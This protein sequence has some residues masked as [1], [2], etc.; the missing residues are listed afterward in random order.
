M[1]AEICDSIDCFSLMGWRYRKRIKIAPGIHLNFSKRGASAT[2]GPRGASVNIGPNGTYVNTGIPNTG[3]YN[4]QKISSKAND[5]SNHNAFSTVHST[6][7]GRNLRSGKNRGE[8]N[9]DVLIPLIGLFVII[10]IVLVYVFDNHGIMTNGTCIFVAAAISAFVVLMIYFLIVAIK[11]SNENEN[12]G[13][14]VEISQNLDSVLDDV[15]DGDEVEED[16]EEG[17]VEEEIEEPWPPQGVEIEPYDPKSDLEQYHYPTI[18]LLRYYEQLPYADAKQEERN[19]ER[20]IS[21]LRSFGVE[22]SAVRCTI[23]PSVTLYEIMLAPGIRASRLNGLE[24]D[25]AL[26]MCSHNV[27]IHP[28]S[29]RGIISI[30][31]PNISPHL[32]PI[33]C[34]IQRRCFQETTMELP[35][36][37]G[38]T[39]HNDVFMFDLAKAP[40]LLIAGSAGQG[41][42]M[43][44]HVIITSLLYKCH[45]SE[46]KFVLMDPVGSEL[47]QYEQLTG[48]FLASVPSV[49]SIVTNTNDALKTLESLRIE[50]HNRYKLFSMAGA[51][52][53]REYDELFRN[54]Q[55]NPSRGH[56]YMPRIVVVIDSYI[57]L[58]TGHEQEMTQALEQLIEGA[59]AVG[60]HIIVS[61]S[62]PSSDILSSAI[63]ANMPTRISFA[64]PE[65]IDSHI[66]LGCNGAE[67][68]IR[69]GDMIFKNKLMFERIQCAY[70]DSYETQRIVSSVSSQQGYNYAF[71]LPS[72]YNDEWRTNDAD[73][74]HLDPLFEDVALYIVQTKKASTSQI[75]DA[76]SIGYNRTRRLMNQL[77]KAGVIGVSY[78]SEQRKVLIHD[79]KTL[80]ELFDCLN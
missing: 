42:S 21:T 80:Y 4:R 35:C 25:I 32:L 31:V 6:S 73:I 79:L 22:I 58:A 49:D 59:R 65:S 37:L 44:L 34:I 1:Q 60:I 76:F 8:S 69:P 26:S 74:E 30:I 66:I 12:L 9:F 63:K 38:F 53:I 3:L 78:G 36:A 13:S 28:I 43:A 56:K 72:H 2:I 67:D 41:K 57:V 47:G 61:V 52:D 71:P 39:M 17:E 16:D 19:K 62:H 75:Q 15:A 20:L 29:S 5:V 24:D 23:G 11:K 40:H 14:D 10:L 7:Y 50:M 48:H 18:D 70:V 64:L 27:Q 46:L 55:L 68:L 77:E 33:K 51:R 54:W 45:P